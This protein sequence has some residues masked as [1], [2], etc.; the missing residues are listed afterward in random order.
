MMQYNILPDAF[1]LPLCQVLRYSS[2]YSASFVFCTFMEKLIYMVE[3][4][5][6][7]AEVK[8]IK[9]KSNNICMVYNNLKKKCS[10]AK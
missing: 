1:K 3:F 8:E 7:K 10:T 4:F 5:K 2:F 9:V 6:I